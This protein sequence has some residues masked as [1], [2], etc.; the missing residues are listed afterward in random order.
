MLFV[1]FEFFVN[2]ICK[3]TTFWNRIELKFILFYTC[4]D[5]PNSGKEC[6]GGGG[7]L[8]TIGGDNWKFYWGENVL[9]VGGNMSRGDLAIR[10]LFKAKT[11]F[12]EY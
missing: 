9:L 12:C 1:C 4:Q 2:I 10:A 11:A 3:F 7:K 6:G 8:P 5:F